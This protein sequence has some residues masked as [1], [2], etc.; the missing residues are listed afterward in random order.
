MATYVIY[1]SSTNFM[2]QGNT[3]ERLQ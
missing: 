1:L 3:E 2:I